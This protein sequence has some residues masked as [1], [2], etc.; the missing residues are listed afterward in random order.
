MVEERPGDPQIPSMALFIFFDMVVPGP[1]SR[2]FSFFSY[3][4]PSL[5]NKWRDLWLSM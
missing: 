3:L 4:R 2:Y 5:A 1:F